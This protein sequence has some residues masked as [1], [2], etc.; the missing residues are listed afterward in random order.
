RPGSAAPAQDGDT[1][2]TGAEP[3][4]PAEPDAAESLLAPSALAG[5]LILSPPTRDGRLDGFVS[6]QLAELGLIGAL[7]DG[8]DGL[9]GHVDARLG[10]SGTL[11]SPSVSGLVTATDLAA[12]LPALG[13]DVT[14]GRL[15]A[16]VGEVAELDAVPF[17]A[18]LCSI[19]CARVVGRL[20]LPDGDW[21]L[22]ANVEGDNVLIVDLPELRAIESPR[23]EVRATPELA[24][25]AGTLSIPE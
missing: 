15:S 25:I 12:E 17:E 21:M 7:V 6:A 1:A 22:A 11:E 10:L 13:I 18:E 20:A 19:G 4:P 9:S 16:G 5:R 3:S 23:L 14:E 8:V 2:E 24:P